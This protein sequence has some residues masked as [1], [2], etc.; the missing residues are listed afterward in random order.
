MPSAH[1]P[2]VE[3]TGT[4][5]T[6]ANGYLAQFSIGGGKRKGTVLSTCKTEDEA[7]RRQRE[8]AKIVARLRACGQS[9]M[10]SNTIRDAGDLD[11]EG[12]RKLSRLVERIATGKEPGLA[13]RHTARREGITVAEL[14]KLWTTGQLAEQYPDHVRAKKSSDDD[15]RIFAWLS[16]V[17]MPDGL[18]FGDRPVAGVT[19]DDC[20]HIL[21]SLPKS[22]EAPAS[23][24]HYA[25]SLRKLLVYAVYPLRLLPALPIPK[26][27]LP[28]V[29]NDKAK[30]WI[31][32]AED[33]ALMQCRKV[34]VARR[35][36]FGVLTR[37]GLRVSEALGLTWSDIDLERG[38]VRLD[39]NKT[40][41]PRSWAIG[42]D[43]ARALTA[44]KEHR[45]TRAQTASRVF[46]KALV[47]ERIK[48]APMLRQGL[49]LAG[50]ARSELVKPMPGRLM[51]RAHDLRGTF[52]TLA[53]AAGR[54]E[55]WVTDRTGHRSS[56][57]IYL[58]KRSARTAAE[59]ELGWLAPLDEAIPEL[60][61]SDRQGA[62][63]V[64]TGGQRGRPGARRGS[65]NAEK[66]ARRHR[67][68]PASG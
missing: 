7:K 27:W 16:K 59:L 28:K 13:Q 12:M 48:L 3:N 4:L 46:P 44:W 64:Q 30:A 24:R 68:G 36:L 57:M 56:K 9:A 63:G 35:L 37:E 20:D 18:S 52:V 45:G 22:A 41:D 62:N 65:R 32:P 49:E 25:Q 51:M 23:R 40:D 33:L 43:V 58:Y 19:L 29:G 17:R 67:S 53:L 31:Y 8:I 26:G 21:G 54:T 11:E 34:P 55:A 10:L 6:T 60:V 14:A 1:T 2:S 38:I 39:T 61:P 66:R 47:G 15:A 50:V 42:G 5:I